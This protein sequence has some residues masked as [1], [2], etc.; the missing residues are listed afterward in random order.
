[1]SHKGNVYKVQRIGKKEI[2]YLVSDNGKRWAHGDTLDDA[3]KS[4]IY[5]ISNRDTG[6]Y[7]MMTLDT[8]LS[9]E[10]AIE[11]YRVITGACAFGT[12]NFVENILSSK[13]RKDNYTIKEMIELTKGQYNAKKF[14]AF[15]KK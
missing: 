7:K 9:F 11:C 14:A 10:E 8:V 4:L 12:Q 5:K 1:M 13:D 6:R 15:F 3:R 2:F